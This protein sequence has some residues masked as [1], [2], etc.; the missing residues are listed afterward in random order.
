MKQIILFLLLSIIALPQGITDK[1]K[2]VIG[3]MNVEG[4]G[5]TAYIPDIVYAD[6]STN[7]SS[8]NIDTLGFNHWGSIQAN[9]LILLVLINEGE[10]N[11]QWGTG[12]DTVSEAGWV[13]VKDSGNAAVDT[14]IGLFYKVATGS[15]SGHF[16]VHS[17]EL[18]EG[19]GF[20]LVLDSVDVTAP[21]N[22]VGDVTTEE[23]GLTSRQLVFSAATT[24][25]DYC[26]A[27]ALMGVNSVSAYNFDSL[28]VSNSG[29][30]NADYTMNRINT[31]TSWGAYATKDVITSGS[32]GAVTIFYGNDGTD[33]NRS[34]G[35]IV[36]IKGDN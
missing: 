29:W 7:T 25:E 5:A 28:A 27:L 1:H 20:Y 17:S 12:A 24:T 11:Q 13:F 14:H 34:V 33:F 4:G 19:C 6:S 22:V 32:T 31:G 35:F 23:G 3:R 26:F 9:H 21:L 2:S 15:E 16:T 8:D 30:G 36:A 18:R 10:A